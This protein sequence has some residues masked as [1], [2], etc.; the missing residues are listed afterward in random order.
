VSDPITF[1]PPVAREEV[2][3][4]GLEAVVEEST[5]GLGDE[6][7][8]RIL[9][10]VPGYAEAIVDA[11]RRS[12]LAGNVDHQL[13]ELVRI[14][15][16]RTARDP[17]FSALRSRPA[18]AAGLDE[19]RVEAACGD[20]EADAR[21]SDA[22][23]WALRFAYLMYREAERL[24]AA[25]YEEGKAHFTEAQIMELGSMIALHYG[26]AMFLRTLQPQRADGG[27]H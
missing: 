9:G 24:D 19:E 22:E 5:R 2:A 4:R 25:F 18:V 13:K 12:H 14:Q 21:F 27:A 10:H 17:Y 16:A 11:M 8:V 3:S 23:K 15:L 26:M 7:F 6:L 20:F 1:V